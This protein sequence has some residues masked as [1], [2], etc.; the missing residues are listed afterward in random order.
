MQTNTIL[1]VEQIGG[2][3]PKIAEKKSEPITCDQP[4]EFEFERWIIARQ[5]NCCRVIDKY[6]F[7]AYILLFC[8]FVD[9]L[10]HF[11]TYENCVGLREYLWCYLC[12]QT[13]PIID[14]CNIERCMICNLLSPLLKEVI[15]NND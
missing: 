8:I 4:E 11:L 5:V 7:P 3:N 10:V 15:G 2:C 14:H 13:A 9:V 1:N 12:S 6:V